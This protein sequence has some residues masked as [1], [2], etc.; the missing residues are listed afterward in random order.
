[1]ISINT[2]Q[3]FVGLYAYQISIKGK[4]NPMTES[5]HTPNKTDSTGYA[6]QMLSYGLLSEDQRF[7][8]SIN[9]S[10]AYIFADSLNMLCIK[11]NIK[12][13]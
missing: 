12:K 5:I 13:N 7:R 6:H 11:S 3:F 1:M 8:I 2:P 4:S 9:H 10:F